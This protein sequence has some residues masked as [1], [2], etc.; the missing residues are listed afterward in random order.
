MKQLLRNNILAFTLLLAT[1][2]AFSQ[3]SET[4]V[5]LEYSNVTVEFFVD[6][7]S[8]TLHAKTTTE[9]TFRSATD[10]HYVLDNYIPFDSQSS[11]EGIK[12]KKG[13]RWKKV[14]PVISD[15]E[16][17]GVFH[18]DLRIAYFDHVF[19]KRNELVKVT[20]TKVYS[21]VK[22]LE[23]F[24]FN[25]RI[26][27]ENSSV[28]IVV[29]DWLN[30]NIKEWNFDINQPTVTYNTEEGNTRHEYKF[31]DMDA[32]QSLEATPS[33][34]K[35]YP[36]LVIIPSGYEYNGTKYPMMK[37]TENLYN[38]YYSLIT[39]M[40]NKSEKLQQVVDQLVTGKESDIEK[41]KSIYYWVQDNIRYIA[42]EYGIMGFKP[43]NCQGVFDK[44]FG[45]C[46]GMA[47]LTKQ[48]LLLAGIDAR[49]TWLG[50]QDI[51][52]HYD[53]MP[54]LL[55]DNHMI[56]TAIIDDNKY[57]LDPTEKFIDIHFNAYRISGKDVLIEDGENYILEKIPVFDTQKNRMS[58]QNNLEL[59]G[60]KLLGVGN[61]NYTGSRKSYMLYVLS[62]ITKDKH[63]EYIEYVLSQDNSNVKI[64]LAAIPE[65]DLRGQDLFL[66]YS[67]LLLNRI[68]EIDNEMYVNVET[69]Y[70]LNNKVI[71]KD[72]KVPFEFS[73]TFVLESSTAFKIPIDF[74]VKYLPEEILIEN[75]NFDFYVSY[76]LVDN[77]IKYEKRIHLKNVLINV[78]DFEIWNAAI[79]KLKVSYSDQIILEKTKN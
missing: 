41:T 18:S 29:P 35:L 6:K 20:F 62:N 15:Y 40:D 31:K 65:S 59:A 34:S 23:P 5:I 28:I 60:D 24:Y 53:D 7:K 48:M 64:S 4:K 79:E 47:N 74:K 10:L 46:K 56:C 44:K 69:D 16:L 75:D 72:R 8:N 12:Y 78:S 50:T 9:Q 14:N 54:S 76:S 68:I 38:W 51:P 30:L 43:D 58:K 37:S 67:I 70:F 33:R 22:F 61:V 57:F 63:K 39:D 52:Y 55:V 11:I 3:K 32:I 1:V 21:D 13:K 66:E 25:H 27:C 45:D 42:F 26:P 2:H 17:N 73:E 19:E 49:L 36:H 77:T 71:D